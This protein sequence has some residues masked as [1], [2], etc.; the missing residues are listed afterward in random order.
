MGIGDGDG[1]IN[2]DKHRRREWKCIATGLWCE[3]WDHTPSGLDDITSTSL[4]N[5]RCCCC[6]NDDD[7]DDGDSLSKETVAGDQ[8]RLV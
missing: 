2:D 3:G 1:A 5:W 6:C 7:D 4:R 8:F